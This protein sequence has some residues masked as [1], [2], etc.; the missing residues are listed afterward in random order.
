M[1]VANA[2]AITTAVGRS[3]TSTSPGNDSMIPE[4]AR[5]AHASACR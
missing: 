2:F 4:V 3:G 5:R 1:R